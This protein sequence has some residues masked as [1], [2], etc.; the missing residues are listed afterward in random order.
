VLAFT[1]DDRAEAAWRIVIYD[2]ERK[3]YSLRAIEAATGISKSTVANM[4]KALTSALDWGD[5]R[6][7]SWHEVKRGT[8][9]EV[10]P[11]DWKEKQARAFAARLRK[12]FGDKPDVLP[13]VF[14][15]AIEYTYPRLLS[16]I[17]ERVATEHRDE[18]LEVA[19]ALAEEGDF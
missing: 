3:S 8:R 7:L 5:P 6:E 13:E 9:P 4:R 2:E 17:I 18:V 19:E 14:L 12:H 11:D 16:W 15:N 10:E 1:D